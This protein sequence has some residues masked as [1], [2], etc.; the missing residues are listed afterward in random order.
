MT[1]EGTPLPTENKAASEADSLIS[2]GV[3]AGEEALEK[4]AET[5]E[6]VLAFPVIKQV[7]EAFVHWLLGLA[8]RAGQILVTFGITRAQGNAE[9]SD[10]IAA[11]KEVETAIQS[12]DS[13]AIA[14]AEQ[15]FQRAQSGAV[16]SDGSAQPQ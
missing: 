14:K 11:E 15:D 8:S 1:D 5:A 9:N 12:G 6:P 3:Q 7:F 13:N 16:N 4:A 10:L 2:G